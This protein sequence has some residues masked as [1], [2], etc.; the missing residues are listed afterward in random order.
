MGRLALCFRAESQ[1]VPGGWLEA[2]QRR[3]ISSMRADCRMQGVDQYSV[4]LQIDRSQ[5][6]R[7]YC[8]F[9]ASQIGQSPFPDCWILASRL[10][11]SQ[12]LTTRLVSEAHTMTRE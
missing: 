10:S 11:D 6:A 9:D 7:R 8:C 5:P 2:A 4:F 12:H 1:G 3:L